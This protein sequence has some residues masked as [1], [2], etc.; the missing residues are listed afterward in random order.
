M[1]HA[2]YDLCWLLG[3]VLLLPVWI[4]RGIADPGFRRMAAER[5]GAGERLPKRG[6]RVLIHAV[7]VGEVKVAQAA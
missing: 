6:P 3:F 5:I 4:V 2:V 1:L 7:S